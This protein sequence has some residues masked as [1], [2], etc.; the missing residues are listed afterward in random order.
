M[1]SKL[2]FDTRTYQ[3]L[4]KFILETNSSEVFRVEHE[5]VPW[6]SNLFLVLTI[7]RTSTSLFSC[8]SHSLSNL[9]TITFLGK[10][11]VK[12]GYYIMWQ[13]IGM[14]ILTFTSAFL[15]YTVRINIC[16]H[17]EYGYFVCFLIAGFFLLMSL[18]SLPVFEYEYESDH[19]INWNEVKSIV[20]RGHYILMYMT[21]F[22]VGAAVSFQTFWEFWYLD[23]LEAG[24]L[25]M[26][27]ATAI[28][29]SLLAIF[30][31]VSPRVM[32]KIGDLFT[33]CIAL[34]L[35]TMA[36]FAMSFTRIYWYVLAIDFL[37]AAAYGLSSS[38]LTVH[39]SKAGSKAISGTILG[40]FCMYT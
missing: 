3:L 8:V 20:F 17:R 14:G 33:L 25:I 39:F 7:S 31:F 10:E 13:Q 29:R 32:K 35:F 6:S 21:T 37:H 4:S 1:K 15:T 11:R 38:A 24:P 34:L 28:R 9:A 16:N 40:K 12:Y 30:L 23:G 18:I 26:G 2:L 19:V 22:C 5:S 36:F 27:T